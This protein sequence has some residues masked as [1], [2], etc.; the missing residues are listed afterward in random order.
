MKEVWKDIEDYEGLYQVSNHGRIRSLGHDT[1]HT[2]RILK[3]HLDGKGNYYVICLHKN[4]TLKH[5]LVHRLVAQAFIPNPNNLP[6]VNH[7]DE[8][9]T[10]NR[11]DNLEFCTISYNA[12][13]GMASRN[14]LDARKMSGGITAEKAVIQYDMDGNIIAEYVSIMDASRTLGINK[15]SI[16]NCCHCKLGKNSFNGFVFEFKK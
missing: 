13:Y 7:K 12:R 10:N 3:P 5:C 14:Q 9:K 15:T 8:V 2:G 6:C 4:K 16:S 1:W 11:A